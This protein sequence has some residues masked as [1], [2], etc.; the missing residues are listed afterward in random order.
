VDRLVQ[1]S[2][3][4]ELGDAKRRLRARHDV[5]RRVVRQPGRTK[6]VPQVIMEAFAV[7]GVQLRTRDS[8]GWILGME[9]EWEPRDLGA[10]P[11]P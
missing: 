8:L 7:A 4:R 10:V 1:I 2:I 6:R 9:V 11:A 5:G 3:A